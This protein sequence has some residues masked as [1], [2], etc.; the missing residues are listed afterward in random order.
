M[1]ST[2]VVSECAAIAIR[3]P[4]H[5]IYMGDVNKVKSI[6]QVIEMSYAAM[7]MPKQTLHTQSTPSKKTTTTT[8]NSVQVVS[9]KINI[10]NG[11]SNNSNNTNGRKYEKKKS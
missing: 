1:K 2:V 9:T 4:D 8:R 10:K 11:N 3:W 5:A 7:M 6:V